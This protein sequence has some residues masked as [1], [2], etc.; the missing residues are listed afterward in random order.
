[1]QQNASQFSFSSHEQF[2]CIGAARSESGVLR[3]FSCFQDVLRPIQQHGPSTKSSR[4]LRREKYTSNST[5]RT[6]KDAPKRIDDL[7]RCVCQLRKCD[8]GAILRSCCGC[9]KLAGATQISQV[10]QHGWLGKA[11]IRDLKVV[12]RCGGLTSLQ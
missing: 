6:R 7:S 10:C 9:Q 4:T 12:T 3:V 2:F 5:N 8:D 11:R 1:M